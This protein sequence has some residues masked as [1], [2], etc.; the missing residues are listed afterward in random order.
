[1]LSG[2]FGAAFDSLY[3]FIFAVGARAQWV[4]F[5]DHAPGA[6]THVNATRYHI[7]GN[8]QPSAGPLRKIN[9]GTNLPAVLTI[10][11]TAS[12]V[13]ANSSA[14]RPAGGTPLSQVFYG[15][16]DF[17]GS[18]D[19]SVEVAGAG[20]VTY[21]FSN[22]STSMLYRFHGS[23]IRG[24]VDY[25][26][27]WALCEIVGAQGYTG[28]HSAH[29]LSR[30]SVPALSVAQAALNSGVNHTSDTGDY[31]SWDN[32]QPGTN[33][34]FSVTCRQYTGV[35]PGGTS[36]GSK[37]YALNGLRL[38]EFSN[39]EVPPLIA[40]QPA[41]QRVF[42]GQTAVL[43]A[44]AT[45]SP[46]FYQWLRDGLAIEGATNR[47][48]S[49]TCAGRTDSGPYS[50]IVSNRLGTVFSSNATVTVVVPQIIEWGRNEFGQVNVPFNLSNVVMMAAGSWHGLALQADGR[51][52]GWGRNDFGQ[53]TIP[54]DAQNPAA[55]AAGFYF[56]MALLSNG[57]VRCW[58]DN[59][60]GQCNVPPGLS[61]VVLIAPG[62]DHAVVLKA[63]GTVVAWGRNSS[64]QTL[65]P[66]GLSNVV[67]IRASGHYTLALKGDGKLVAWGSYDCA[68]IV[69]PPPTL[70]NVV[71]M[72]AANLHT[73]ALQAN[74]VLVAWGDNSVGQTTPQPGLSNTI[75]IA[76]GNGFSGSHSV[77]LK[78]DATVAAWGYNNFNQSTLPPCLQRAC[79]IAAS[80]YY[81]MLMNAED[82]TTLGPVLL[83][84]P[85]VAGVVG[86][87]V[88]HRFALRNGPA[89]MRA[90]GLPPGLDID[91]ASGLLTGLPTTAGTFPFEITAS[92]A[93]GIT[94]RT[95]TLI[96]QPNGDAPFITEQPASH[97]AF[98]GGSTVF[99]SGATSSTPLRFQWF[100]NGAILNGETN[101]KLVLNPVQLAQAGTYRVFID[102]TGGAA[103][104]DSAT[105]R[106]LEY[107]RF[108]TSAA[109]FDPSNQLF[110][111]NLQPVQGYGSIII[112][113]STDLS[114]W[115]PIYTN[116]SPAD[117]FELTRSAE[118]GESGRFFRALGTPAK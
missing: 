95:I 19:P 114:T 11:R 20:V 65:V 27:R 16:V 60:W 111:L 92:N 61:N 110:H 102:S 97:V 69:S 104:S 55:I 91:S 94:S 113:T 32:I 13:V 56:S 66:P 74:G 21:T 40:N 43:T 105:L 83:A 63:D 28:A 36:N 48:F 31:V 78:S 117:L 101:A 85:F 25:T 72:A 71:A 73:L 29:V 64:G 52:I 39:V 41:D 108:E 82:V 106:V 33:G 38:E 116:S 23:A 68:G 98:V 103:W 57:T 115:E 59:S 42:E 35:V 9:T 3:V 18:P 67:N 80:E 87:P 79:A 96:V 99:H 76:A 90:S 88:F 62:Y 15:F 26:N 53:V 89:Q 81:T 45:G 58:G 1:M 46:L 30:S 112:E 22:L 34:T 8:Q 49:I 6:E 54:P 84:D 17:I 109:W 107:P 93:V 12:G 100:F 75:A 50:F 4:A 86:R 7:F 44:D 47:V 14:A 77:A 2:K 37:G 10:T 51:V 5:N 118:P 24:A 70:S